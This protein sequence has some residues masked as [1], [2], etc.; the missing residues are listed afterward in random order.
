M[1]EEINK[2][3]LALNTKKCRFMYKRTEMLGYE[4]ST[5]GIKSQEKSVRA[6]KEFKQPENVREVRSFWGV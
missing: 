3:N 5:E 2:A 1:L 4:V 6:I